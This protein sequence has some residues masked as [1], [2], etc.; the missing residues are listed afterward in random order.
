VVVGASSK[1][2]D[3]R[4]QSVVH[5]RDSIDQDLRALFLLVRRDFLIDTVQV[6]L[7]AMT[8]KR[9]S[10]VTLGLPSAALVTGLHTCQ[11]S[12]LD[13]LIVQPTCWARAAFR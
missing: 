13:H 1:Q 9:S 11:L 8:T 2:V 12:I 4:F 6:I 3:L 5:L 7:L 10:L